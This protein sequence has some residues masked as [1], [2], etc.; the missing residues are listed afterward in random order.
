MHSV[1]APKATRSGFVPSIRTTP[2]QF[3]PSDLKGHRRVVANLPANV[4]LYDISRQGTALLSAGSVRWGILGAA[5]GD[6][7]ERD[8]SCLDGGVLM[9]ISSDGGLIAA[10]VAGEGA[11]PKGSIYT[12]KTDGSA[13]IAPGRRRGVRYLSGWQMG[14]WLRRRR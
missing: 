1:G 8:L 9:G 11:G 2:K 13:T 6:S 7:Q 10:T 3:T 4:E 12:R 5:P 14:L